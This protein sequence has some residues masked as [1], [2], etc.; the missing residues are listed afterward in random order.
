MYITADRQHRSRDLNFLLMHII[1]SSQTVKRIHS[2]QTQIPI[3]SPFF[4]ID[5]PC[6]LLRPPRPPSTAI[7]SSLPHSTFFSTGKMNPR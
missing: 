7:N 5:D 2:L 6:S 3:L 4:I 1:L